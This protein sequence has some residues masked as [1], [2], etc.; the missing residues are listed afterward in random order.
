[1]SGNRLAAARRLEFA[2]GLLAA[3]EA[4]DAAAAAEAATEADPSYPEAWFALGEAAEKAGLP[5]RAEGAYRRYLEEEP[6][7]RLGA[8]ARLVLLAAE[9]PPAALPEAYVR[10]LFDDYAPRFD[11]ALVGQLAYRGPAILFEALAGGAAAADGN[12]TAAGNPMADRPARFR[13]ALDLGCGTGLVGEALRPL[14]RRLEGLDL[15]PAMLAQARRRGCY[16]ALEAG[17][18]VAALER[19]AAAG[20]RYDL[21]VAGDV[22]TYLGRLGPLLAAVAAVLPAGGL[23][24]ATTERQD[25]PEPVVLGSGHRFQHSPAHMLASCRAAGLRVERLDPVVLR[26]EAGRP[27]PSL[28]T[29]ARKRSLPERVKAGPTL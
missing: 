25:G 17:E 13:R 22:L 12:P 28:L 5:A 26:L 8:I 24:A 15:S 1:M 11:R 7:D 18:A 23:F 14:C 10:A 2:L 21:V 27:V 6:A 20:E 4:V 19:R 16:D 3:G 9:A 29:V